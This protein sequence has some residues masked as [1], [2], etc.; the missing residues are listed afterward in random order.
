MALLL[1]PLALILIRSQ[2]PPQDTIT[3]DSVMVEAAIIEQPVDTLYLELKMQQRMLEEIIEKK[4]NN[5]E[6]R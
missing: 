2:D 3:V 5:N 6:E 1:L 4:K